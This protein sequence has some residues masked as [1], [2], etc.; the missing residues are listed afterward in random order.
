MDLRY[1]TF[2]ESLEIK[3]F[4]AILESFDPKDEKRVQDFFIKSDGDMDKVIRL[5]QT[6][7]K[8][9]TDVEKAIRRGEAAL[10]V[11]K[12]PSGTYNA[13]AEIFFDRAL[14]LGA[15]ASRIPKMSAPSGTASTA[16]AGT[17]SGT[18]AT[19]PAPTPASSTPAPA[20]KPKPKPV[21]T[22]KTPEPTEEPAS[23]LRKEDRYHPTEN[24]YEKA[25]SYSTGVKLSSAGTVDFNTGR[26]LKDDTTIE[27]WE[28]LTLSS[29]MGDYVAIFNE[30]DA[31]SCP[32]GTKAHFILDSGKQ[33]FLAEMVDYVRNK[34]ARGLMGLYGDSVQGFSY[35]TI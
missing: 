6:M 22:T 8:K 32:L 4:E 2:L 9:I 29:N 3:E 24:P 10:S 17:A 15:S 1:E 25:K 27:I 19:P 5:A 18:T 33:L 14:E 11:M 13:V 26:N 16:S 23:K 35:V 34:D 7:A 30:G 20:P 21:S 31:P 12:T 28:V